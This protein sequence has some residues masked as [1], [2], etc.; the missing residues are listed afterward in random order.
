MSL[1]FSEC[2]HIYSRFLLTCT[3]G[4][5]SLSYL[6]TVNRI[7]FLKLLSVCRECLQMFHYEPLLGQLQILCG[8]AH[9]CKILSSSQRFSIFKWT[10]C[11]KLSKSE[12][13]FCGRLFVLDECLCNED[14]KTC[15]NGLDH[16]FG[17][18][19][20]FLCPRLWA[21]NLGMCFVCLFYW[22]TKVSYMSPLFTKALVQQSYWKI[23]ATC[24][25]ISWQ[26]SITLS[27]FS[28]YS[29]H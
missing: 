9:S 17:I 3:C 16:D 11:C 27:P 6:E 18:H 22:R 8:K 14:Q 10:H 29:N 13:R 4:S 24:F 15:H 20:I 25:L 23:W 2:G 26:N 21:F 19:I 28:S 7:C 5:T 1:T 12:N